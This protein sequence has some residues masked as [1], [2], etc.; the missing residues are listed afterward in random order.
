MAWQ[1]AAGEQVPRGR[2]PHVL[3]HHWLVKVH[4]LLLKIVST[5]QHDKVRVAALSVL[6]VLPPQV[7]TAEALVVPTLEVLLTIWTT[8]DYKTTEEV[9]P[10]PVMSV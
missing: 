4:P 2:P 3:L 9:G 10:C 7:L 5:I 1:E 8:T 6:Q